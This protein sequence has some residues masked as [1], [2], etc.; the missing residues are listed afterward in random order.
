MRV[1][2]NVRVR[3][4]RPVRFKRAGFG[5]GLYSPGS[6]SGLNGSPADPSAPPD[7]LRMGHPMPELWLVPFVVSTGLFGSWRTDSSGDVVPVTTTSGPLS[8]IDGFAVSITGL[9]AVPTSGCVS[10]AGVDWTVER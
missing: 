6:T 2:R 8:R 4:S 1:V 7:L 5:S 9:A 10:V 3:L